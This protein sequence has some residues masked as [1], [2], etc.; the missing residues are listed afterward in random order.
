MIAPVAADDNP[1]EFSK[2][3]GIML[4]YTCQN[5]QMDINAKPINIVRLLLS[6]IKLTMPSFH[7]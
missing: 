2:I 3:S 7:Q 5:A 6:F 1:N 4:S